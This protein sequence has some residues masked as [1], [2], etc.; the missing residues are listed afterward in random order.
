MR[1]HDCSIREGRTGADGR[2]EESSGR[3][4]LL[5][6]G[7]LFRRVPA[8]LAIAVLW[9]AALQADPEMIPKT[10]KVVVKQQNRDLVVPLSFIRISARALHRTR[11]IYPL[12]AYHCLR[13]GKR[14]SIAWETLKSH[15]PN[16][17]EFDHFINF[18]KGL[19][20]FS[21]P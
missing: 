5:G 17:P 8:K 19:L 7:G 16:R 1:R 11:V 12:N 2:K 4:L 13:S 18:I 21:P 6:R 15:V 20:R 3:L 10:S 14:Q 9:C